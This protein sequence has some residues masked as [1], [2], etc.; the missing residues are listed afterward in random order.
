MN[1]NK[2]LLLLLLILVVL[3]V[4]SHAQLWSGILKPTSGSGACASGSVA[5]ANQCAIDWSASGIPGGIPS[6]SWAQ[7]GSTIQASS[8]SNGSSD[9]TSTIQSALNSC[10]NKGVV[11]LGAG[12]FQIAGNLNIPSYCALRGAGAQKTILSS[13]ASSGAL[14]R[15]GA[16]NDDP[17]SGNSGKVVSGANAGS[18]GMVVSGASTGSYPTSLANCSGQSAC[19]GYLLVTEANDPVYVTVSTVQNPPPGCTYC[20]AG[21]WG[22][23]RVRGQIVEITSVVANGSN[24]TIT[25][26][27]PLYTNYGASSGTG[28]A[29]A[30]PFGAMK[31]GSPDVEWAGVE[32]L[33]IYAN[34]T[35]VKS[36]V[37]NIVITECAYCWVKGIESNYTD[38]D[39]I[40]VEFGFRNEI[41]DSYF[42]GAYLHGAGGADS[43]IMLGGKTSGT[44]V[45]NNILERLHTSIMMNWGAAGNVIAYNYSMGSFDTN[46]YNTN[47][48]DFAF[49][50]AH[51]QFNLFEGNVGPNFQPDSWHGS[52]SHN[53]TFRNW[54]T[55]ITQVAPFAVSGCA[56]PWTA[57]A[58]Y[59]GRN[60]IDWA[61][62]HWTY[63]QSRSI[64]IGYPNTSMNIVGDALGSDATSA[65]AAGNLYNSGPSSCTSCLL[66]ETQRNYSTKDTPPISAFYAYSFGYDTGGDQDG[67]AVASFPGGPSNSGGYWVGLSFRTSFLHGDYDASSASTLWNVHGS[68]N[69]N[70]AASFYRSSKP[71]W[72]GNA[73]WPAIGP[74]VEGGPDKATG[75]HANYIPA[76]ICYNSTARDSNGIKTFDPVSCYGTAPPPPAPPSGLSANVQ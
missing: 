20:D 68:G 41:R 22:G 19:N 76:E 60:R 39:H 66:A 57:Q 72:F 42:T 74:D 31:N 16:L 11:E 13:Q 28:P 26:D 4:C 49:H 2:N 62:A 37:G 53:T 10:G 27:P 24:W 69:Q 1:R 36:G 59:T 34:G 7:A 54:W 6:A 30:T 38:A 3:P 75:G 29:F 44:L 21:M 45:E 17:Y 50:G 9:C 52:T 47:M 64:P 65:M 18:T 67:S 51:P 12:T 73:P 14:V 40:D 71:S 70:L 48:I 63:Q 33:Q 23:G 56:A 43:D 55:G 46:G 15:M 25:F 5:L 58:C 8:C 32:N 35:G 61:D